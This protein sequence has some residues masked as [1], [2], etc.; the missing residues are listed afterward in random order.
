ML[1]TDHLAVGESVIEFGTCNERLLDHAK[2]PGVTFSARSIQGVWDMDM[3]GALFFVCVR[4]WWGDVKFMYIKWI[5]YGTTS[6][7]F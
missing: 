2:V 3:E 4:G 1:N 7:Y 6:P 5:E